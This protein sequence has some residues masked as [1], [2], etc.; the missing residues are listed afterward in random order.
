M[1]ASPDGKTI[2]VSASSGATFIYVSTNGGAS[3]KTALTDSTLGGSP[4]HDLA[5]ISLTEGFAVIGNATRP[6]TRNS[7]LLMTRNRGLSWQKVTF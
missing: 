7:K 1:I 3:W 2:A 4:V 5:F 6:G